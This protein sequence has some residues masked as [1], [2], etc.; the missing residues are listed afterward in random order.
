MTNRSVPFAPLKEKTTCFLGASDL[1]LAT[2]VFHFRGWVL[3]TLGPF[4][5]CRREILSV[6]AFSWVINHSQSE[7]GARLVL[8]VIAW[9]ADQDGKDAWPSV[10]TLARKSRL[11]VRDVQYC[12]RKLEQSGELET[13]PNCGPHG[14]NLYSLPQMRGVQPIAGG[15]QST[16]VPVRNLRHEGVQPIAP[17]PSLTVH[18]DKEAFVRSVETKIKDAEK[19]AKQRFVQGYIQHQRNKKAMVQ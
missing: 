14:T 13:Q 17:D 12:L 19:G 10:A 18:E 8:L 15:V 3:H 2:L 7:Q 9:H 1:D 6:Q 11:S 4:L 5:L 16:T